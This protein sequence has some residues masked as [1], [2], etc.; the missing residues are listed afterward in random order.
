MVQLL[1]EFKA[2]L[3]ACLAQAFQDNELFRNTQKEAFEHFIN[4]V[5]VPH[6]SF[7][8]LPFVTARVH[9]WACVS[10]CMH[11]CASASM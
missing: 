11:T 1:L 10:V 6:S 7:L 9:A 3:D 4:Q 2:R 5:P 8:T